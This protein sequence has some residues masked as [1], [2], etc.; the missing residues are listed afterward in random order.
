MHV[1]RAEQPRPVTAPRAAAPEHRE[2]GMCLYAGE[3]AVQA[4]R[5][6]ERAP[7]RE[8]G[9]A[10][11]QAVERQRIGVHVGEHAQDIGAGIEPNDTAYDAR[12]SVALV[13]PQRTAEPCILERAGERAPRV[14]FA[15]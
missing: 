6:G 12:V 5:S 7:E 3:I 4:D 14:A 1:A 8:R 10:A 9:H 13:M 15:L 2:I 11:G